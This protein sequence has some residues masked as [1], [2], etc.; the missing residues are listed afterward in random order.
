LFEEFESVFSLMAKNC[1]SARVT[2]SELN[3]PVIIFF[4]GVT[5]TLIAFDCSLN[6][7]KE[8][9]VGNARVTLCI[10]AV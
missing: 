3:N 10:N 6:N 8:S 2:S 7:H 9:W 5:A 4:M 1:I